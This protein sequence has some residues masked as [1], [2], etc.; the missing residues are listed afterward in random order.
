MKKISAWRWG[1]RVF[2]EYLYPALC[3][4]CREERP[5]GMTT[6][7][8]VMKTDPDGVLRRCFCARCYSDF[9]VSRG[10][11]CHACGKPYSI[12]EC[13]PPPLAKAGVTR[14]YACFAYE[15]ERRKSASSKLIYSLKSA[16]NRDSIN[17]ASHL[18]ASRIRGVCGDDLAD[19]TLTFAPRGS[20]N[21]RLNGGDHM[22]M[23]AK[24]TS[25][26]LGCEFADIFRNGSHGEQ[27]LRG[28]DERAAASSAI[29]LKRGVNVSGRRF[30]IIDDIITSGATLGACAGLLYNA[31][32]DE[33]SVFALAKTARRNRSELGT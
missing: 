6:G 16:E 1:L 8:Y 32:A 26:L 18:L 29:K 13:A 23:T 5:L 12:C 31:G 27:K 19:V 25:R 9:L 11:K 10:V 28:A 20:K 21:V 15:K 17:F 33:V 14:T 2:S 7:E 24:L 30:I 3:I 22:K 4:S